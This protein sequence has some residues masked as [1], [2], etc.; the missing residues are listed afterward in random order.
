MLLHDVK[1]GTIDVVRQQ[2]RV[3]GSARQLDLAAGGVDQ[4]PVFIVLRENAAHIADVVGHACKDEMRVILR[5]HVGVQRPAAQN[6]VAC[7]RDQH[8]VLDV[9]VERVAVADAF[10]RDTGDRR[11][12]LDQA[13]FG[14]AVSPL[15]VAREKSA[16]GVGRELRNGYHDRS[17]SAQ[18]FDGD[19]IA[20]HAFISAG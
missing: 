7:Q 3:R 10:E 6:V 1:L 5:R 15:H 14:G 18:G 8:C 17:P 4:K 11:N 2:R 20:W 16:E 9:V 12:Q 19:L 13:R